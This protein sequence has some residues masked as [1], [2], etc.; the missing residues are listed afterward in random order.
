ML[1]QARAEIAALREQL[2]AR[3]REISEALERQ[4]ATSEILRVISGSTTDLRP[5]LNAICESAAR[6]CGVDDVIVHRTDGDTTRPVAHFGSLSSLPMEVPQPI[7]TG[8][9]NGRA[10]LE[11]RT[12]YLP[13]F[14]AV[15]AEE[16]PVTAAV[17][18]TVAGGRVRSFLA[19]P[20]LRDGAAIGTFF[21]RHRAPHAFGDQQVALLQT[22]ADQAVIAIENARLFDEL[23]TRNHELSEALEQQT[24]TADVLR[25]ISS[26]PMDLERV[27]PLVIARAVTLVGAA[28]G[29]ISRDIVE[30]G[31]RWRW[32][33]TRYVRGAATPETTAVQ[34]FLPPM[35]APVSQA[36]VERRT[37]HF[38]GTLDEF[39]QQFPDAPEQNY[40]PNWL[41]VPLVGESAVIGALR[42]FRQVPEPF[43]ERQIALAETFADQAVIAIENARLFSELQDRNRALTESLEQQTAT[44]EVLS[45]ISRSPTALSPVLEAIVERAARLCAAEDGYIFLREG[46]LLR[47]TATYDPGGTIGPLSGTAYPITPRR[48]GYRPMLEGRTEHVYGTNAELARAY[49]D[50]P[51]PRQRDPRA[52]MT[53]LSTPLLREGQAIGHIML[54]RVGGVPFTAQQVA[55][56]EA[57]AAQAVI[58]IENTRL[59]TELQVRTQEVEERNTRLTE[60]LEYQQATSEVL[61]LIA[62]APVQL[63]AVLDGIVERTARLCAAPTAAILFAEGEQ[64]RAAAVHQTLALRIGSTLPLGRA[65][66]WG[67]AVLERRTVYY[68]AGVEYVERL[69][70]GTGAFMRHQKMSER[71]DVAVPLVHGDRVV[72]VLAALRSDAQGFTTA[73]IALVETFAAQAVIA[74]ENARL[75]EEIQQK[76]TELEA[77]NARLETATQHKS[78]FI[79]SM[80]HELRTP[81]NAIIGYSEMLQ[82]EAEALEQ[83]TM[84]A[85]LEKVNAAGKHLLSLINNVL[86]LSKIEAGRMD[87]YLEDFAVDML[88]GDVM[89][90]VR[91]LMEKNGNT[92]AIEADDDLGVM[93]ADLTKVRQALFNLL[94]NA[95]KF[96]DHGT[97]TLTANHGVVEGVDMISFAVRDTGIGMT[98]EQQTRLFQ[99]FSQAEADTSHRFGGTGLGLALSRE[100]CQMMG[101]DITVES[102]PGAGSTFVIRL[103]MTVVE[104]VPVP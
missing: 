29:A 80:S 36:R 20:L 73:Q 69:F 92:L 7:T 81:L 74:I 28:E 1:V 31:D 71:T 15:P 77:I 97:I 37:V 52:R 50:S 90:V 47:A 100:F 12:V 72:G 44:A 103:P 5:V 25:I 3:E 48:I 78:A 40:R 102:A 54:R 53:A 35:R 38:W 65:S 86:D 41:V 27:L 63:Q 67:A 26:A 34:E 39:R 18:G 99:A 9:V 62:R 79:S 2:A 83:T 75:F 46:D 98:E 17:N 8:A 95:A 13:D 96:T 57:F 33:L 76:S 23:Q 51:D 49:P 101:G 68:A 82:E 45:I 60:T 22:F 14:D 24:A 55:L 21:L 10:I 61:D 11:R 84:T 32:L 56:V 58:A 16:Y 88:I 91:P 59:F 104:S 66:S 70:P 30:D 19:V 85:D 42:L 64:L 89:A 87:L 94:S 6:L 4:A 93:H 43:S